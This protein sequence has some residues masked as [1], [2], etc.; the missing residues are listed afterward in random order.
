MYYEIISEDEFHNVKVK[1]FLPTEN[2]ANILRHSFYLIECY[3]IHAMTF[4]SFNLTDITPESLAKRIGLLPVDNTKLDK[5][6][7]IYHYEF[8][9]QMDIMTSD[10]PEIPFRDNHLVACLKRKEDKLSFD[11]FIDKDK[12]SAKYQVISSPG[13][14]KMNDHFLFCFQ[15]IGIF[16]TDY[17]MKTAFNYMEKIVGNPNTP[18]NN[19]FYKISILKESEEF[20][21]N[22]T[23]YD[24]E[25]LD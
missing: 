4:Y 20:I 14:V 24:I 3:K 12:G 15:N 13:F 5:D 7:K 10:F 25:E 23:K 8:K 9:G 19:F 17:I 22:M 1:V 2:L 6:V 18:D 11:L 21:K 16:D